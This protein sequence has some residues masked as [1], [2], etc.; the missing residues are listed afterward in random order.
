M[1]ERIRRRR[2]IGTRVR[3]E[4]QFN[5]TQTS[6]RVL[7][8]NRV[9]VLE[10]D[11]DIGRHSGTLGEQGKRFQQKVAL[12]NILLCLGHQ[13]DRFLGTKLT[14]LQAERQ[15]VLGRLHLNLITKLNEIL[16]DVLEV[17][18]GHCNDGAER[19]RR[20]LNG[21]DI[22]LHQIEVLR[23]HHLLL[24]VHNANAKTTAVRLLHKEQQGVLVLNLLH[25]LVEVDEVNAEDTLL[26]AE[27]L[28][29]A[30]GVQAHVDENGVRAVH[31]HNLDAGSVD[32]QIHLREDILDG[33]Y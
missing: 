26:G 9:V 2:R 27:E 24:A 20:N 7:N 32:L 3:R 8:N 19:Y 15:L 25:H 12:N 30:V 6:H 14:T 17:K 21:L 4:S 23:R 31:R 10:V 33:I 5:L 11:D 28:V 13:A 16:D 29:E 1:R 22:Q 18:T